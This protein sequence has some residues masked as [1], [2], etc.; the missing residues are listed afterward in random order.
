MRSRTVAISRTKERM[1]DPEVRQRIMDGMQ[2]ASGEAADIQ[3]LHIAW[4]AAPPA[5]RARFLVELTRADSHPAEATVR[6][7]GGG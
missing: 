6:G 1:V 3:M 7:M 4:L 5:T 2:A